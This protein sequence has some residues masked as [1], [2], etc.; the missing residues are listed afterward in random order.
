MQRY[1]LVVWCSGRER[2]SR[3]LL[4]ATNVC[5]GDRGGVAVGARKQVGMA[6]RARLH[7][8]AS[9]H[10]QGGSSACDAAVKPVELLH[11]LRSRARQIQCLE[12]C[13]VIAC[14]PASGARTARWR[15]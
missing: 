1:T 13:L 9:I 8:N 7:A 11:M 2:R 6:L 14:K 15:T 12:A 4:I 5:A 10:A 3:W